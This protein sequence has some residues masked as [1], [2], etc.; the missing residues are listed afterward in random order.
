MKYSFTIRDRNLPA[1][2]M[3]RTGYDYDSASE[4]F[5]EAID[6][7]S[8]LADTV[9]EAFFNSADIEVRVDGEE[10]DATDGDSYVFTLDEVRQ[11]IA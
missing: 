5:G 4:A 1:A 6:T 7:L 9:E 2:F 3:P 8:E 10:E 11:A